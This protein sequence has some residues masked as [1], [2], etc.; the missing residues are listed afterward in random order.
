MR[1]HAKRQYRAEAAHLFPNTFVAS[2]DDF[3]SGNIKRLQGKSGQ[4]YQT[5][6]E[7][8]Q[9][10]DRLV[11]H[12]DCSTECGDWFRFISSGP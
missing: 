8:K 11:P 2:A 12:H 4:A 3:T 9:A 10:A 5:L 6:D 7:A 1:H